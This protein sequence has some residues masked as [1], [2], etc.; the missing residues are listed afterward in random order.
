MSRTS[1]IIISFSVLAIILFVPLFYLA[2]SSVCPPCQ[3]TEWVWEDICGFQNACEYTWGYESLGCCT[4]AYNDPEIPTEDCD[5]P[6]SL[7]LVSRWTLDGTCTN[8]SSAICE[9]SYTSE[10]GSICMNNSWS[11]TM[12]HNCGLDT[13]IEDIWI[14]YPQCGD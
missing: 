4:G 1:K 6:I 14:N 7:G 8:P 9:S 10:E 3:T 2:H 11:K 12:Y 5:N 13:F